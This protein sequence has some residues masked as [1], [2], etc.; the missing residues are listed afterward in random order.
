MHEINLDAVNPDGAIREM[1]AEVAGDTRLSFLRKAGLT[2]GAM[3]GGGAVVG[4][5]G[6]SPAFA[7]S[8]GRPPTSF[9]GI[10]FGKGDVGILNYALTLEH[11]EAAFYNEATSSGA[12]TDPATAAF[13]AVV[14]KDENTHVK[15]LTAAIKKAGGKPAAT[16]KFDFQGTTKDLMMFQ[17]TAQ[18]LENTGVHA[19]FG[20]GFNIKK[21]AYLKVAVSIITVEARHAGA[22]GLILANGDATSAAKNITPSGAFDTPFTAAKVLS[23]V[24][25][26]GFITG[27]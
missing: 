2:G 7:A 12:I 26:T 17:Q 23:A 24:K 8:S 11:L 18:T 27:V 13:L 16:P 9:A 22:I 4:A 15:A 1:E 21:A 10:K 3:V 19:Y 20:Q 14:T 25:G 5:L 6:A